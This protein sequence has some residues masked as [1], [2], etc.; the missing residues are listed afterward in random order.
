MKTPAP[1]LPFLLVESILSSKAA[2]VM[3]TRKW[4]QTIFRTRVEDVSLEEMRVPALCGP[5]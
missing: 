5:P 3:M 4:G 2:L 1:G